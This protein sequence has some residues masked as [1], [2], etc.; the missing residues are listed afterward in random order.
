MKSPNTDVIGFH[1]IEHR[2]N[3]TE[4]DFEQITGEHFPKLIKGILKN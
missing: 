1:K 3:G 2:K 4:V